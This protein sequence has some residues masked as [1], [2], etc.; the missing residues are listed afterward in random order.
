[1]SLDLIGI[2]HDT[3]DSIRTAIAGG[4][5]VTLNLV[6]LNC[7]HTHSGPMMYRHLFAGIEPAPKIE[8]DY[9]NSLADKIIL[10]ARRAAK[11]LVP[12]E[13]ELFH[14]TSRI[15]INRRGKDRQGH[16]GILPNPTGP[17]E[18]NVWI[19]RLSHPDGRPAA[20]VFSHACHPV[21]VYGFAHSAISADY[22][23]AARK[24][25]REKLGTNVHVQFVQGLAGNIRPRVNADV[26]NNRW[27]SG[28]LADVQTAGRELADDVLTAL[29]QNGQRLTLNLAGAMDRPFLPRSGPPPRAIY[30]KMLGGTNEFQKAVARYWLKR[31]D[32][33]EGFARGDSW[34]VGLIRLAENQWVAY[35][36]GE[37]VVEWGPKIAAWLAPRKT[38]VWGYCQESISYLPTEELLPQAGYEVLQSNQNRATTPA[39]FAPGIHEAIRKSLLGLAAFV[40]LVDTL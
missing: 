38:V 1:V 29:K 25:V 21:I 3:S 15:G 10:A 33:E 20:I 8:T 28:S 5:G 36:A 22:P 24:A 6:V 40:E 30:E 34:P 27:R 35:L 2:Q 39:P 19:L 9:L 4:L 16:P 23:G 18:T 26:E 11:S 7:S 37:P 12:I 14:G 32:A 17:S 31:Y 13:V